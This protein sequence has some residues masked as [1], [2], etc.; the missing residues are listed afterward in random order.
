MWR[1]GWQPAD[2]VRIAARRL[3]DWHGRAAADLIAWEMRAYASATVDERR[4][5]Q[6]AGLEAAVWWKGGYLV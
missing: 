5:D 4:R 1:N 3:T 6:L 2:V